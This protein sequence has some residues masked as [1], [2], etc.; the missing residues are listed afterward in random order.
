MTKTNISEKET[1]N[2]KDKIVRCAMQLFNEKSYHEVTVD[3]IIEAS[4]TSKGGF[5]YY[6]ESKEELL[7]YWLPG[8][9]EEYKEWYEKVDKSLPSATLLLMF[10]KFIMRATECAATPD[11]LTI[12]Y[13][14]QLK[15]KS[16]RKIFDNQR[17]LYRI[18]YDIIRD[19]QERGEFDDTYSFKEIGRMIITVIRGTM[20]EWCLNDGTSSI[21]EY[22][23]RIMECLITSFKTK[24]N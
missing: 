8:L 21:E 23:G 15:M 1:K 19:G 24:H 2:I 18:L 5:Y 3:E 7:I 4:E 6:F 11:M 16:K 17:N 14:A 10:S 13:S 9:D 12:I 20:Y 22:G